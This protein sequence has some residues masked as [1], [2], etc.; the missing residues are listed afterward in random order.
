MSPK[1]H[2]ATRRSEDNPGKKRACEGFQ[3]VAASGPARTRTTPMDTASYGTSGFAARTTDNPEMTAA[4]E[5]ANAL[6]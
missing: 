2:N 3:V 6:F 4:S 1:R 5:I